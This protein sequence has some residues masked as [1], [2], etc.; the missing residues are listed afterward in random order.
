SR[1]IRWIDF[2]EEDAERAN[3]GWEAV[4]S[5][6][7]R[8]FSNGACLETNRSLKR[9]DVVRNLK[10]SLVGPSHQGY[11]CNCFWSYRFHASCYGYRNTRAVFRSVGVDRRHISHIRC[12]QASRLRPGLAL[13]AHYWNY[14]DYCGAAYL[15]RTPG[16]GTGSGY[17]HRSLGAYD[18][19]V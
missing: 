5:S 10:A 17:L 19:C 1:V 15:P 7:Y 9:S 13:A 11:R 4:V 6:A 18:W 14:W 3:D 12:D 8:Y 2:S 16:H